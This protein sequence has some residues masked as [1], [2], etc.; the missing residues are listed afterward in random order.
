[1]LSTDWD[2]LKILDCHGKHCAL[3]LLGELSVSASVP[4]CY[5]Q[6]VGKSRFKASHDL[7]RL[8]HGFFP[9]TEIPTFL[10][11][12][13]DISWLLHQK[14]TMPNRGRSCKVMAWPVMLP[15]NAQKCFMIR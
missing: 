14:Q 7:R 6:N 5:P 11:V 1:M 4:H 10:T 9:N 12:A 2:P 13:A 15:E 8:A 3:L